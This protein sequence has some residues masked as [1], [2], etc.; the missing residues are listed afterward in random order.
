MQAYFDTLL[1]G[2]ET[3]YWFAQIATLTLKGVLILSA[4]GL[5]AYTLRKSSAAVRYLV[6]CSGLLSLMLLPVLSTVLPQWQVEVL[7]GTERVLRVPAAAEGG[8][9]WSR[10]ESEAMP[11]PVAPAPEPPPTPAVA[12]SP[13]EGMKAFLDVDVSA[14]ADLH[15][16]TLAFVIWFVGA[17]IILGRLVIA[18]IGAYMLVK[19]SELVHDDDWHFLLESIQQRMGIQELV[20]LRMSDWTSV[21]MSVGV[22]RPA[23]VLPR[24]AGEWDEEQRRT[25]LIHEL[26]HVKRRDCLLHL[27][28]Q[29]TCALHWFNPLVWVAS[30][31]LRV[32]R[33][34]A[35]DDEVLKFGV[36]PSHYA[37][38]LLQ[39]ARGIRKAEWST[40]A[41]VSMARYSQLEGRLL[42]ILDP[43]RHRDLNAAGTALTLS[44]VAC[45]VV[46][47]AIL[48]PVQAQQKVGP[49]KAPPYPGMA[50]VDSPDVDVDP[51]IA[52][53][54]DVKIPPVIV[55]KIVIPE[56]DIE[57]PEIEI[58]EMEFSF[59]H[60][61]GDL[62][63]TPIDS[64]TIDQIIQLRKYG[65]D[66]AFIRALKDMGYTDITYRELVS[67]GKYGADADFIRDMRD[68]GYT[69]QSL[70]E[71]A[72]M[73]KYG[74]DTGFV[75]AMNDAGFQGLSAGDLIEMSKYGV[76]NDLVATLRA[77]GYTDLTVD[78]MVKASKYGVDQRLI[79]SLNAAGYDALSIDDL[80]D[81]SKYGVDDELI[82]TLGRYGYTDLS[83]DALIDMS[84]YGVNEKLIV[85]VRQN[86]FDAS[87]D[88]IIDMSK[89]GVDEEL[90]GEIRELGLDVSADELIDMSK[91]GVD[92]DYVREM[93]GAGLD[94]VTVDELIEMRKHGVDA[95]YIRE[96]RGN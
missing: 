92:G 27:F 28:T 66:G 22:W 9:S 96:M 12:E 51:V 68:A 77:N 25:V 91:Y 14:L 23:V 26:A 21:P 62:P 5:L 79:E 94:N 67:A 84:K 35:C 93:L 72:E 16:T 75:R 24:S 63:D 89:Y 7:P 30:W 6:W 34:R 31:R 29:I 49:P 33:E 47:L 55:P 18:H 36:D 40:I 1:G 73:S 86:N 50:G 45:I 48:R 95:D 37:E 80:V 90:I 2:A 61:H 59:R 52:P 58:P 88:E 10:L 41:A 15:W 53:D 32:E 74:V 70:M 46:P 43:V 87:V 78:E 11:P 38:T 4:T 3:G 69:S 56:L 8:S 65:V 64:L 85:A 57:I 42:S 19:R 20:R 60:G 54:I 44:L 13:P 76:D 17:F 81:M 82:E 83:A 71:Y 39:T